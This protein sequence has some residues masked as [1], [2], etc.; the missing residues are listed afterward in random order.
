MENG[1][2]KF[3]KTEYRK[4]KAVNRKRETE[5]G[6]QSPIPADLILELAFVLKGVAPQ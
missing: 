1:K 6:K 5:N 2:L 3:K 4:W